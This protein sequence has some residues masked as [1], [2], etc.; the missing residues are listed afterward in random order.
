MGGN[1]YYEQEVEMT[2]VKEE[3]WQVYFESLMAYII[4]EILRSKSGTSRLYGKPDLA[5]N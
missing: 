2:R 1:Y 3:S 4:V 5:Y